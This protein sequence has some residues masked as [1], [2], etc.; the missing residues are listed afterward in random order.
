MVTGGSYRCGN[1]NN[2]QR[3]LIAMLLSALSA[4]SVTSLTINYIQDFF[5]AH[6]SATDVASD[7]WGYSYDTL[8][9]GKSEPQE[10]PLRRKRFLRTIIQE[11]QSIFRTKSLKKNETQLN[12]KNMEGFHCYCLDLRLTMLICQAGK[13]EPIAKKSISNIEN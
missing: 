11:N 12:E 6:Q 1:R 7:S 13:I 5:F 3:C 2:V 8:T 9:L 10:Y 4:T